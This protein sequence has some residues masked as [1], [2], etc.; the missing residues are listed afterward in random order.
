MFVQSSSRSEVRDAL[1]QTR[2]LLTQHALLD[3]ARASPTLH[4][5]GHA[6]EML[7]DMRRRYEEPFRLAILGDFK[8][9]KS[10]LVNSVLG[11][12]GMLPEGV[13]PTTGCVTELWW[14]DTEAGEVRDRADTL[15]FAGTRAAAARFADQRNPESRQIAGKGARVVIRLPNDVLKNL[16]VI[17]TP[18]LGASQADDR[19]TLGALHTADA[20]IL[21]LSALRPGGESAVN[22]AER[23]RVTRK[24]MI[25]VVTRADQVAAEGRQ[26]ALQVAKELFGEVIDGEPILFASPSVRDALDRLASAQ[27]AGDAAAVAGAQRDLETWG[28][29]ALRERLLADYFAFGGRAS[30]ERA[31][32]TLAEV[33]KALQVLAQSATAELDTVERQAEE[34][35]KALSEAERVVDKV[36]RP[37]I[38]YLETRV[39]EIIDGHVGEFVAD[40][41]EAVEIYI[42]TV[43]D[44]GLLGG[45]KDVFASEKKRIARIQR[46][47]DELFPE[48]HI[49]RTIRGIE[50]ATRRL[51]EFEWQNISADVAARVPEGSFDPSA[52]VKDMVAHFAGLARLMGGELA[53]YVLLL[54]VPGGIIVD[55]IALA[56]LLA[57][58]GAHATNQKES[59]RIAH[60]KRKARFGIRGHR[61]SLT[62]K[63][64]IHF[65]NLNQRTG[66]LIIGRVRAGASEK[67]KV[68]LR[69]VELAERWRRAHRDLKG[70][71][72]GIAAM[73]SA[74]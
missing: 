47:F 54:L 67:Q 59:A 21:V 4:S 22:L 69:Q 68:H 72:E 13:T 46:E 44:R 34:T 49:Q 60:A 48:D 31:E 35:Q 24:R 57:G 32:G 9:G 2:T 15:L 71:L 61:K 63:L 27:R 10:S 19:A 58:A 51:L 74:T 3:E 70:L 7:T 62:E 66:D 37:K 36:L 64:A 29:L 55:L 16:I 20:A 73:A 30:S 45:I 38:P 52:I 40:L 41:A 11:L 23:L 50:R 42:D 12:P 5:F 28:Y 8:V 1:D 53:A 26:D 18:G 17:D 65:Y 56:G 6:L 25:A 43:V 33:S 14:G 39:D